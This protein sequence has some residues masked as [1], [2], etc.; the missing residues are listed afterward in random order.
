MLILYLSLALVVSFICSLLEATIL[1]VSYGYIEALR[2]KGRKGGKILG[3]LKERIDR[4]LA[5]IL[6][7]NT[8]AHTVGA[9]GVGG[10]VLKLYTQHYGAG[11]AGEAVAVASAVLTFLILVFSANTQDDWG[12]VLEAIGTGSGLHYQ[13]ID[14][15]NISAGAG[16]RGDIEVDIGQTLPDEGFS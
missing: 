1:S 4:P 3:E 2:K 11:Y 7:L 12:G 9:A 13:G 16:V 6:T 10:Q 15:V 14:L 8:V 5:A